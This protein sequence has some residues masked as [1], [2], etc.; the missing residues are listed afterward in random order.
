MITRDDVIG[1][2]QAYACAP[3]AQDHFVKLLDEYV[4]QERAEARTPWF[5]IF[6]FFLLGLVIGS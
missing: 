6:W 1:A 3:S 2:A 5:V 4:K